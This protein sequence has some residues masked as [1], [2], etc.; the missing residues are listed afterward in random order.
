MNKYGAKKTILHGIKYDSKKESNRGWELELC[1]RQNL[2]KELERQKHFELQP[3]FIDNMGGV[4]RKIEYICDFYY[5]DNELGCYVAE[6]V[7]SPA[8]A[9]DKTYII[10]KKL[11]MYKY[12]NIRFK[13]II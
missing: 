10:K 11:F 3:S 5:F 13:E 8:T 6:D 1:E 12:P 2:I 7:K 9:K 4:H